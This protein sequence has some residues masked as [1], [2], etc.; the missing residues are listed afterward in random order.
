MFPRSL[1]FPLRQEQEFFR[2]AFLWRGNA[3]K[4]Y[5]KKWDVPQ[6]A[7]VV[8]AFVGGAVVRN[9]LK[10]VVRAKLLSLFQ[11]TAIEG[12]PIA[13]VVY[14]KQPD[15]RGALLDLEKFWNTYDKKTG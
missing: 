10:R 1:R 6:A 14:V 12:R 8:P 13:V 4:V 2:E 7:V 5:W 11:Q 15:E 9:R 3:I